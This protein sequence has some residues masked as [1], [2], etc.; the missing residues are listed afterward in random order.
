MN[1]PSAVSHH[2][3]GKEI[4]FQNEESGT[5]GSDGT[6]TIE[7]KSR[8]NYFV[9][10]DNEPAQLNAP[11]LEF[12]VPDQIFT[13]QARVRTPLRSIYDAGGLIVR[14]GTSWAKLVVELSPFEKPTIVSVVTKETSDDS[15][16]EEV[17]DDWIFLRLHRNHGVYAFHWSLDGKVW[18]LARYFGLG[19]PDE[20]VC[21]GMIAQAPMGGPILVEF[22]EIKLVPGVTLDVRN[23]S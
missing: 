10:P 4:R 9:N 15:N 16:G 18:K 7:A 19:L 3:D 11:F 22:D 2:F 14:V 12:D 17:A 20:Q 21:M 23:G 5:A 6:L 1:A 13:L 8:T